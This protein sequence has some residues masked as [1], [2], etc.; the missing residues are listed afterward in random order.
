MPDI[1]AARV[2]R[3]IR[4]LGDH[5]SGMTAAF[6]A[7]ARLGGCKAAEPGDLEA[8]RKQ[9]GWSVYGEA[10]NIGYRLGRRLLE[11]E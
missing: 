3:A 4:V 9:F 1:Y 10:I 7:A 5:S 11:P 2:L 8:L 6:L